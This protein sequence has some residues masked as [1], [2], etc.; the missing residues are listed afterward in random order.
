MAAL[1]AAE[2][3][4]ARL[5]DFAAGHWQVAPEAVHFTHLGVQVGAEVVA[6]AEIVRAAYMA[7]VH[8]SAAGSAFVILSH[9]HALD[10]LL[11]A[12]GLARGD[13]AYIGMIGSAT[14]RARLARWCR[15][16]RNG[17]DIAALTCP[18]GAATLGDKRPEVMAALTHRATRATICRATT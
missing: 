10:F 7:R 1:D 16:H 11:V 4:T 18:I 8:L 5:V 14:K 15:D 9:D 12:Q 17:L 2:Q 3:I 13:A 6:L